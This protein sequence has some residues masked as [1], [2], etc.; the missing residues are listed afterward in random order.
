MHNKELRTPASVERVGWRPGPWAR[1]AGI[2]KTKTF[3][4]IRTKAIE[5]RKLGKATLILTPP[6]EYLASLPK[7]A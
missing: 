7:R 5:A 6:G 3:E 2:G 4:L 1:A